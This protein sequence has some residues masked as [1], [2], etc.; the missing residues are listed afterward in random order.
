MF[1]AAD[2]GQHR[3][4]AG[5]FAQALIPLIFRAVTARTQTRTKI[6]ELGMGAIP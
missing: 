4:A 5:A 6:L 2:R 3:Q 1:G